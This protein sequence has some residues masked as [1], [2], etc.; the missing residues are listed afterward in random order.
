MTKRVIVLCDPRWVDQPAG[1]KLQSDLEK[2]GVQVVLVWV[3]FHS[4]PAVRFYDQDK[5]PEGDLKQVK[6][7]VPVG[8]R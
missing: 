4:D 3:E 6:G 5:L 8:S 7:L 2:L 1:D